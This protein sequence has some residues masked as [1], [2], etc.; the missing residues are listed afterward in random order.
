MDTPD[1]FNDASSLPHEPEIT[2]NSADFASPV[3]VPSHKSTTQVRRKAARRKAKPS[4][5]ELDNEI[6]DDQEP[7][8][9]SKPSNRPRTYE[10][11]ESASLDFQCSPTAP[12]PDTKSH[13][14]YLSGC[15]NQASDVSTPA[16]IDRFLYDCDDEHDK[17]SQNKYLSGCANYTSEVSTP[18]SVPGFAYDWDDDDPQS[19]HSPHHA[20]V[21]QQSAEVEQRSI[22]EH[23]GLFE[24]LLRSGLVEIASNAA[25]PEPW[26]Q[27]GKLWSGMRGESAIGTEETNNSEG[28]S[29]QG[30]SIVN[31]EVKMLTLVVETD[32]SAGDHVVNKFS[33]SALPPSR[34]NSPATIKTEPKTA[35]KKCSTKE[36][37]KEPKKKAARQAATRQKKPIANQPKRRRAKQ[38]PSLE[39]FS[40]GE[41]NNVAVT[42]GS[43]LQGK[44]E[45]NVRNRSRQAEFKPLKSPINSHLAATQDIISISSGLS[46]SFE[47]DDEGDDDFVPTS[48]QQIDSINS[49]ARAATRYRAAKP[50]SRSLN[51]SRAAHEKLAT[52][53]SAAGVKPKTPPKQTNKTSS[54]H[55]KSL[56]AT[57][58]RVRPPV[59]NE[60]SLATPAPSD[61]KQSNAANQSAI[62]NVTENNTQLEENAGVSIPASSKFRQTKSRLVNKPGHTLEADSAAVNDSRNLGVDSNSRDG[63]KSNFK[64]QR[65]AQISVSQPHGR[66]CLPSTEDVASATVKAEST[67]VSREVRKQRPTKMA[68]SH[69]DRHQAGGNAQ[70]F[71]PVAEADEENQCTEPVFEY[72]AHVEGTLLDSAST[73]RVPDDCYMAVSDDGLIDYADGESAT[74]VEALST[75]NVNSIVLAENNNN[76]PAKQVKVHV[77]LQKDSPDENN[78]ARAVTRDQLATGPNPLKRRLPEERSVTLTARPINRGS[79]FRDCLQPMS[80]SSSVQRSIDSIVPPLNKRNVAKKPRL[81]ALPT[82]AK[83]PNEQLASGAAASRIIVC[84]SGDD[85]FKSGYQDDTIK[86]TTAFVRKCTSKPT[87]NHGHTRIEAFASS[88]NQHDEQ[89]R[90]QALHQPDT[91]TNRVLAAISNPTVHENTKY[92]SHDESG[93]SSLHDGHHSLC[94]QPRASEMD[95]REQ[96]WKKAAEPYGEGIGETMHRT[97]NVIL[98]SLKTKEDAIDDVIEDYGMEGKRIVSRLSAEHEKERKRL[99]Q[100]YEQCRL[101]YIQACLEARRRTKSTLNDLMSEDL[102][103]IMTGVGRDPAVGRLKKLQWAI[104]R[105][106]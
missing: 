58:V 2:P 34:G 74:G 15:T 45:K 59:K 56:N 70:T 25:S 9:D 55:K 18:A 1:P 14:K 68:R 49:K 65:T 47:E 76:L 24:G 66:H 105:A 28:L 10:A 63:P 48:N 81:E 104:Q 88:R 22:P 7:G 32:E 35:S 27:K 102:S 93:K 21:P 17:T 64:P 37:A 98:R 77:V 62:I 97:V 53:D 86:R 60:K 92:S 30:N 80:S 57:D 50:V 78:P 103:Q 39:L 71:A 52:D 43:D 41:D 90:V 101:N 38:A 54:F 29:A 94:H 11:F 106:P 4:F 85:V 67:T 79:G 3:P 84:D 46:D 100:Q 20:P 23:E 42:M 12:E 73:D 40:S 75:E 99:A 16:Q 72:Q 5:L 61:A 91:V 36:P 82:S 26:Q 83:S 6:N 33:L 19:S 8:Y 44:E 96:A 89:Q 31:T 95:H 69:P 13:G 87:E 51:G